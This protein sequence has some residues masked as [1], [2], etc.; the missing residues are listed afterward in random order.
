MSGFWLSEE[1]EAIVESVTRLCAGFD[2]DYWRKTDE[3]GDFPEAFVAAMAAGGWLGTAMPAELGGAGLGLTEA[4]LVMQAVAQSG[5][6]FSGASAMHLNIFGPMPIVRYGSQALRNRAI[7]RLMSGEDKI[8]IGITEPDS[9]LDTT[10]L[11]TRAVR[12]NDGYVITG[13]K[14]WTTMAQRANKM[15][16]I[17][18]TTPKDQVKKATEG[19]SLFY[20]DFDR[21]KISATVIPK[22]G[23]KAVE[24]NS[25]FIDNLEVPADDLIGEEGRGF[26][27]LLDGLNPERVLFGAEAVGLGRA[28]L[29]RAAG[30]A[31]ERVVFG[32]PIGQN[33]GV[34]H[35]LAKAWAELEAANLMAFKAA[36]LFDAGRECGAEANAAKY[37]GGEAGFHACEAA[38]LAHGGMGY[39]KE[40]DV[41][42][43]FREA[44]IARIAPI[45]RE[46]V[47]NYIAERVLGLPKSY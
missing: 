30:Y 19:L 5:A 2:A 37:L 31:K 34:A 38:V 4:A 33:Q 16:I 6:G 14:V 7:P 8:C 36:A 32:R 22:M 26:Y 17:A 24:S 35:P 21:S 40:F 9:G 47:M 39:A 23:R 29:A 41:E 44:M 3:T 45:S 13:R 18:R 12:T 46:M 25:V 20:T 10:S 15:L 28:A 1:Q 42:R 43:Y 27:Y 11:T